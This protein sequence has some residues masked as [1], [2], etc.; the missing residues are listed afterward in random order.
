VHLDPV[1]VHEKR[2]ASVGVGLDVV[3]GIVSLP[4]VHGRHVVVGNGGNPL[5]RLAGHSF[6]F[7]QIHNRVPCLLEFRIVGGEPGMKPLGG[8][9]VRVDAGV[10]GGEFL[11]LVE[12]VFGRISRRFVA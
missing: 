7:A 8:V 4:F 5:G 2:L 9:R 6:P 1:H 10:I 12:A 3:D 11:H